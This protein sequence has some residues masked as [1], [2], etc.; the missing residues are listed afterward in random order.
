MEEKT[1]KEI[2]R[3]STIILL[4]I[5]IFTLN[6]LISKTDNVE[7]TNYFI[8][9]A[10]H[11]GCLSNCFYNFDNVSLCNNQCDYLEGNK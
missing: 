3:I 1:K 10:F 5:N 9:Y 11:Q 2:F 7:E 4:I 6:A 8:D